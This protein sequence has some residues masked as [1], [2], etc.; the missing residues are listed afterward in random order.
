[1]RAPRPLVL[2]LA[3]LALLATAGIPAAVGE[4]S[5]SGKP[6]E[7]EGH[8]ERPDDPY[9]PAR[10]K[11]LTAPAAL[12]VRGAYQSVQIN[13]DGSGANILGDAANEPS[14][15]VDPTDPTNLVVGWRQFD[16]IAS[17]F[18]QAGVAYSHDG[19]A[20]WSVPGVVQPGAFRTDP[21]LSA[22]SFGT[23]LYYSLNSLTAGDLWVSTDKGVS[24]SGPYPAAGGDKEWMIADD[25]GSVGAGNVYVTWN[26]Q[27]TCCTADTDFTRSPDG[28]MFGDPQSLPSK[29]KWGTLAVGS[30]GELY[31]IGARIEEEAFPVPHLIMKSTNAKREAQVPAFGAAVGVGLGGETEY[32]KAPNPDGI[33]G[34]VWVAVD[35]ST[36]PTHGYVYALA[37]VNPQGPDPLDIMFARSTDG[38]T[39]WSPPV[40]V[41]DD[42]THNH[43]YQWFGTMSVA[44]TG[45]IDAVW[46][47]TRNDPTEATSELF[48]AYS[49]DAGATWSASVPV[50][51]V[52]NSTVGFPDQEKIGDYYHMVSDALGA[53]VAYAATFNGEQDI[54]FLRVGDCNASGA[55]DATDIASHTSLDCNANLIPDEC[56]EVAPAC[57]VCST[58]GPCSDGLFCDGAE[59]CNL[60]TSRC[61]AP[62]GP[63]CNDT[64][65]CTADSCNEVGDAC[66]NAP[67]PPPGPVPDEVQVT[68]DETTAITTVAWSVIAGADHYNT[69]RGTIP[70]GGMGGAPAGP[71]DHTCLE[72]ADGAGDGAAVSHD[73]D[74]PPPGTAFYF[75][76]GGED[77]CS[78]G[79]LGNSSA[80][81]P[82]PNTLPC[83]TPP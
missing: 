9:M 79:S 37:S 24:W 70:P 31:S 26:S 55:H 48:Y 73:A 1:M 30:Y 81:V 5:A 46:N 22:D 75:I 15:A 65:P 27:F 60:A 32:G 38:G 35:R 47:D 2:G 76:V 6:A 50:S 59:T 63:P 52:W 12:V 44:V 34:Q 49:I 66:L 64:N 28:T 13:V 10:E 51:P 83:P 40:R 67:V 21:V 57:S 36:G 14:L 41:N 74:M 25:T 18:R 29:A 53:S 11:R 20:T 33:M 80:A 62:A 71:Y 77:G 17:N 58:D 4:K 56:E 23:F 78:D 43:A 42:S 19:G 54:Y 7:R 61:Q 72:S 8:H 3:V 16:N 68:Q 69:Y 45:R 39:T 82:R